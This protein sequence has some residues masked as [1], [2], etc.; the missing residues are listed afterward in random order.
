MFICVT[1]LVGKVSRKNI[2]IPFWEYAHISFIPRGTAW[3]KPCQHKHWHIICSSSQQ[4][5]IHMYANDISRI[6]WHC[7]SKTSIIKPFMI[8]QNMYNDPNNNVQVVRTKTTNYELEY[9]IVFH[10]NVFQNFLLNGCDFRPGLSLTNCGPAMP[11][12][13]RH[14]NQHWRQANLFEMQKFLFKYQYE[15]TICKMLYPSIWHKDHPWLL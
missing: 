9:K 2:K 15:N 6:V 12:G 11:N 8:I 5:H 1:A 3:H 13:I 14:L 7:L 10:K 4:F